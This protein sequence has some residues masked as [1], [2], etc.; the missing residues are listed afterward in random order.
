MMRVFFIASILTFCVS[1]WADEGLAGFYWREMGMGIAERDFQTVLIDPVDP[2]LLYVGTGKGLYQTKDGGKNWKRILG[3]HGER[4]AVHRVAIDPRDS[5]VL[6]A[7]TENGLYRTLN[8]AEKWEKVFE[9]IGEFSRRAL[10][11]LL[12]KEDADKIYL[13]TA[14]GFFVSE[15]KGENF[16]RDSGRLSR[17]D[18]GVLAQHPSDPKR[19]FASTG[20]GL[21]RSLDRGGSW[22]KIFV[23]GTDGE[24]SEK[25]GIPDENGEQLAASPEQI[26]AI[27]FSPQ[28]PEHLLIASVRGLYQSLDGGKNW[29]RF[30]GV[31][32]PSSDVRHM[33]FQDQNLVVATEEGIH[34]YS[35]KEGRWER[36]REGLRSEKARFLATTLQGD[37]WAVM[38]EGLYVGRD[39]SFSQTL[40]LEKEGKDLL[41]YFSYEPTIHEI[42]QTAIQYAEVHPEKILAWRRAASRKAWLPTVSTGIDVGIDRNVAVDTGGTTNPDFFIIGPDE[43]GFDWGVD[44][45]WDLSE[46]IYN[47]DQT[48]IDVRSRLLVQLRDDVLDEVTRLYFERRRLQILSLLSPPKDLRETIEKQLKLQELTADI[49]ALTGGYL[50]AALAKVG[51]QDWRASPKAGSQAKKGN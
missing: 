8:G 41:D 5:N 7:A 23:T 37:L 32:L 22:E 36:L 51:R 27:A 16:K 24:G 17:L 2:D 46:L 14:E 25:E 42:Q 30:V 48:S 28:D 12:D 15:D 19:I 43:R 45:S 33:V 21:F 38:E 31:G 47:D 49:D 9:G 11:V 4:K 20:A 40:E 1:A 3:V 26:H 35:E 39:I 13:G 18:I 34:R 50:S 44:L 10:D 29:K 6:F